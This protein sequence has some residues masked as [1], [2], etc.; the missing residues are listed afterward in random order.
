LQST[1]SNF[2]SSLA[3]QRPYVPV[4][5]HPIETGT[6]TLNTMQISRMCDA[7]KTWI[8]NRIPGGIVYGR[9]RLGKTRAIKYLVDELAE[10]YGQEFP[11]YVMLCKRYRASS[12]NT[13]FEDLLRAVGHGIVHGKANDKRARLHSFLVEQ[14]EL[15]GQRRIVLILDE[16]QNLNE[17][18]YGWLM[19]VSNGLDLEGISMTVILV[20]QEELMHK[21]NSFMSSKK[22]QIVGRFM[23]HPFK[24]EG[25]KNL[26]ELKFCLAGYDDLET[27]FPPGS[28]WAFTRYFFPEAYEAGYRLEKCAEDMMEAFKDLRRK[29]GMTGKLEI[30][31]Q[32]FAL[33]VQYCLKRFGAN[34]DRLYFPTKECWQQAILQSGYIEAEVVFNSARPREGSA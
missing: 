26:E 3:G 23:V 29:H 30:P 13:F 28:G 14:G 15:S 19:D 1:E 12:D 17:F 24:F 11:V 6:Y 31:M 20:G 16:A 18:E 2:G 8:E 33:S 25:I 10:E 9:P 27:E 5:S 7:V 21:R 34:G 22:A 4:G 32:Y